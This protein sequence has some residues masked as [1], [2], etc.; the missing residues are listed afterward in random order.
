MHL[1]NL[2]EKINKLY[3][4]YNKQ[5]YIHPDPLEFLYYFDDIKDREIIALIASSL[6][7]GRV[8]QIL[9][10]ISIIL[11]IIGE[12]PY[13]FLMHS[14]YKSLNIAFNGFI[15]RFTKG[16]NISDLLWNI[17]III[18]KFGSLNNCFLCGMKKYDNNMISAI[19]Y[20]SEHLINNKNIGHL[21]AQPQKGSACK[22]MNLFLRWMNRKD[23]VDPGCWNNVPLSDL[24]IPLDTHMHKIGLGLGFTKRKQANMKTAIEIT[25]CFKNLEPKDPVKYDFALT[26]LGIRND[27]DINN[28]LTI[29]TN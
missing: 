11:N 18:D 20:F 12:K 14:N 21:I 28:F 7:Y 17:K 29:E 4:K 6:A 13:L 5:K 24:I 1:N 23:D 26:R 27:L 9:K 8:K 3:N 10:S 19:I 25:S 22:R 15:H 16:N 2:K